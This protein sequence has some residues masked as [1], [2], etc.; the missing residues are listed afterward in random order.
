MLP[1]KGIRGVRLFCLFWR[2]SFSDAKSDSILLCTPKTHQTAHP[3]SYRSKPLVIDRNLKNHEKLHFTQQTHGLRKT[4][5]HVR[6][7]IIL[8]PIW[9]ETS[10]LITDNNNDKTKHAHRQAD[11][12]INIK[13]GKQNFDVIQIKRLLLRVIRKKQNKTKN[14]FLFFFKSARWIYPFDPI[15]FV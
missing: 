6:I 5:L 1:N 2:H 7:F 12:L 8:F 10:I 15:T 3:V 9:H 14:T 11:Y 13:Q 4:S